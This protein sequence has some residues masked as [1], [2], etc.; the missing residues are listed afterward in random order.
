MRKL[1]GYSKGADLKLE[2]NKIVSSGDLRYSI[3][4]IV[5]NNLLYILKLL[6]D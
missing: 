2:D 4:I 3:V 5:N 1:R 6:K